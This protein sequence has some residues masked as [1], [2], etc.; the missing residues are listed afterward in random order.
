[1]QAFA[2]FQLQVVPP[3]NPVRNLDNSLTAEQ[4]TGSDFYSGARPSDGVNSPLADVLLGQQ[5]SFSC[6][7]CHT[8]NGAQGFFRYGRQSEF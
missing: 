1:M 4:K 5:A 2:D 3:P 7:G 8:L 6:N